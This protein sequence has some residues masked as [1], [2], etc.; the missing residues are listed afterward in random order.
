L[1]R[2]ISGSIDRLSGKRL[3]IYQ[4]AMRELAAGDWSLIELGPR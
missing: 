2:Q 4:F 1:A 3:V